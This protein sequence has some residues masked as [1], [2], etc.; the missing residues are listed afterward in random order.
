MFVCRARDWGK[1][2]YRIIRNWTPR[3][4]KQDSSQSEDSRN[5]SP[6]HSA[7]PT[8]GHRE[9]SCRAED[10]M[11]TQAQEEDNVTEFQVATCVQCC[12]VLAHVELHVLCISMEV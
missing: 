10:D 11:D 5:Q 1:T 3:V 6:G 2:D 12:T 8:N 7:A 4:P 9:D